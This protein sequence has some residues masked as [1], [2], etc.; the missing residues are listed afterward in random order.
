MK[1]TMVNG[2]MTSLAFHESP[3]MEDKRFKY[4][5][6]AND[7]IALIADGAY[8]PGDR[9]PSESELIKMFSVSRVTLRESLKKLSMMGIV[10][11]VQGSGTYVEEV[12]P[13]KFMRPL[14]PLLAAK[15]GN[16]EDIYTIRALLESGACELAAEKR[17]AEDVRALER[18]VGGMEAALARIDYAA[19]SELDREFHYTIQKA[20]GNNVMIMIHSLFRRFIDGYTPAI[21]K[22]RDIVARS[23]ADHRRIFEAVES[24]RSRLAA[25]LMREHLVRAKDNLLEIFE[26]ESAADLPVVWSDMSLERS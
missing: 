17:T 12:T 1:Y 13:A 18:L 8:M 15:G 21:N 10:S 20:G 25:L 23:M 5:I 3:P 16:V 9:L 19:Y 2:N 4:D 11:I 7:V 22:S 14:Y 6:I 26:M 24:G